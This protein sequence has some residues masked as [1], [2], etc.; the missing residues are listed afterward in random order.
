MKTAF[1]TTLLSL[2]AGIGLLS[3]QSR[4]ALRL[5]EV[6]LPASPIVAT[7]DCLFEDSQGFLWIGA[8]SG[9]FR[10]DGYALKAYQYDPKDSLSIS[11]NKVTCMAE[12]AQGNFWVGTQVGLNYFEVSKQ[13]FYHFSDTASCGLGKE[14]ISSIII[15]PDQNL[16][17]T[18]ASGV[19]LYDPAKKRFDKVFPEKAA[20]KA[21][22]F[23]A[24]PAETGIFFAFQNQLL[25]VS[26]G[27]APKVVVQFPQKINFLV[28]DTLPRPG[29]PKGLIWISTD[30]GLMRLDR[31][32]L[33]L[34]PVPF[35][36]GKKVQEMYNLRDRILIP[37][38]AEGYFS[39]D[40]ETLHTAGPVPVTVNGV[41]RNIA[42]FRKMFTATRGI[43]WYV[44]N[45]GNFYKSDARKERFRQ[46]PVGKFDETPYL[47]NLFELFEYHPGQLLIP[48]K[49]GA[50]LFHF[51]TGE[52]TPFPHIPPHNREAWDLGVICFLQEAD[53]M[54]WI[55]ASGGLFLLDRKNSRFVH[56]ERDFPELNQLK[57]KKAVIRKI[58]RDR[59]GNLWLATWN[60]GVF[61]INFDRKT[62]Q[63]YLH[64]QE[65]FSAYLQA[66]RTV[67]ETRDGHIWLGTRGGL[68]RYLEDRD[69]FVVYR[70]DPNDPESMSENTSFCIYEDADGNIWSGSYGGGLNHLDLKT[71]KFKHYTTHDG[72]LDNNVFSLLPDDKGNLWIAGFNGLTLFNPENKTFRTFTHHQGLLNNNLAAFVYGK[73]R[74]SKLLFF[75]GSQGLDFFDPD[76][77][78]AGSPAP[79]VWFT[80]FKLFNEPVDLSMPHTPE[81]TLRYNQNVLTFDYAALEY[82]S[83]ETVEYAYWLV[84]FDTTWQ[85]VGNK[86]SITFT[87]LRPDQYILKVKASN[88]DGEWDPAESNVVSIRLVITPPW[89]ATWW[90]R[91]ALALTITGIVTGIYRYRIG[92]V[93]ER[94]ALNQRIAQVKMEALRSQ[95][96]PH[97]VFNCLTS[98]KLFVERNE[99]EKASDHI[100]KFATLL[101]RVLDDARTETETVPLTR[102]LDTLSR[103]V[104]LEMIRFKDKFDF[105]LHLSPD[106]DTDNV[107][108]PPLILQPYVENAILH[109]L[110]H[111]AGNQ[112]LLLVRADGDE[113]QVTIS[114]ED[115]GVGREAARI[116]KAR[117]PLH[118]QS[119]GLNVTAERLDYFSQK[120]GTR[121]SIETTDL[122]HPDG[123]AAGT[124]VTITF[125]PDETP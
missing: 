51:R 13:E 27:Q 6:S 60:A 102:E 123:S 3:A 109:G 64:T 17:V 81:L 96:N 36:E 12:D 4:S 125:Q 34:A 59:K 82:A 7:I 116:F 53:S 21:W 19:N 57:A 48:T 67:Y 108:V 124:R 91:I 2:A 113:R 44:D 77:I 52:F 37:T 72:L 73:S 75:G 33:E 39:V 22:L 16:W 68:L 84:G 30:A 120:Y 40:P 56:L 42:Y 98:L 119:H 99:T 118:R 95:M 18:S 28:S 105:Q 97:F 29:R 5:E 49:T 66:G 26:A 89:W 14:W 15:D 104:E 94:A 111:R 110:Q 41:P 74:Y 31:S 92:Q 61:K 58:H 80:E 78:R 115:N 71:G 54:L 76:S 10:Y 103:Y 45:L 62:F 70:N 1:L 107:E 43:T 83:P 24:A 63:Q 20:Q 23:H 46:T 9:L 38:V 25:Q 101:R 11:D 117:N 93:R 87:N 69:S 85:Y 114:I 55:G 112:G 35:F 47:S 106:L 122:F 50:S 8:Y 90:F 86:R 121:T 65:H 79:R 100:G 32:S 88:G